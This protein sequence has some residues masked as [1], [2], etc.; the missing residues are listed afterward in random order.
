MLNA[1]GPQ[2]VSR[3][4]RIAIIALA[5]ALL[6]LSVPVGA[7]VPT[8]ASVVWGQGGSFTTNTVDNGGISA[9]SL[10]HPASIT[11]DSSGGLYVADANNNRVLYYAAGSTTATLVYGQGGVFT[12]GNPNKGGSVSSVTLDDPTGVALDANGNLYVADHTNNRVLY[13]PAGSTTATRVYGQINFTSSTANTGGTGGNPTASSLSS[14]A[15]VVVDTSGNLYVA[16]SSNNRVL[17]YSAGSTTATRVYGQSGSFTTK[18]VNNGGGGSPGAAT[19]SRPIGVALDGSG[20]LYVADNGNNRVLYYAAGST[21]ATQVWGQ[22]GSFT[23]GTVNGG[24]G[25]GSPTANT[26]NNPD[27]IAVDG[28]GDLYV[29]DEFNNRVVFYAAGSTTATQVYGQGGSFTSS[30][31]NDGGS[32]GTGTMIDPYVALDGSGNLYI[33]DDGNARLLEFYNPAALSVSATHSTPIY[34]GGPAS[35]TLTVVNTGGVTAAAASVTD[36]LTADFTINSASNGCSV[37]GQTVTCTV[38]AGSSAASTS[39]TIYVTASTSASTSTFTNTANLAD[40][41]DTLSISRANDSITIGAQ[42]T[43]VDSSLTQLMLSGTTDNGTCAS[44]NRTLTTTDTIENTSGS[45]IDNP[46]AEIATLSQSN[47]LISQS[48]NVTSVAPAGNV[49]FTFHIQLANC[50]TFQL[51]FDVY[52]N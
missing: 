20:N 42:L 39:F 38:A 46:Y 51:L 35:I 8:T 31:G 29:G 40:S 13:F 1:K 45:T 7:Q 50:A 11:L 15:G 28:N 44:G 14:P 9:T 30:A 5:T 37:S 22:S 23:S 18:T 34:Q 16:D 49:T 36:T 3:S 52:G 25:S 43:K 19:L 12:T 24:M 2:P 10:N 6:P 47:T 17:Y 32:V 33:S 4:R 48:A 41:V 27:S 21:T 26:L